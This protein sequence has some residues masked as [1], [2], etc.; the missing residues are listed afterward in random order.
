[1]VQG[2][3]ER[4]NRFRKYIGRSIS[5]IYLRSGSHCA[6]LHLRCSHLPNA[7]ATSLPTVPGK[8]GVA[9]SGKLGQVFRLHNLLSALRRKYKEGRGLVNGT[10]RKVELPPNLTNT[11]D[12]LTVANPPA[13]GQK[14]F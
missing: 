7:Q 6:T 13:P 12:G 14:V 1:M 2:E 4:K 9:R 11:E 3:P 10:V 5:L 8:A